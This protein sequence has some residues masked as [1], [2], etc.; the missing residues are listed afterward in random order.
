M[1]SVDVLQDIGNKNPDISSFFFHRFPTQRLLQQAFN[2]WTSTEE[3]LFD[4]ALEMKK[5]YQL[6]FWDGIMLGQFNTPHYSPK[7][8]KAALHHNTITEYIQVPKEYVAIRCMDML[9]IYPRI[10]VCSRICMKDKNVLHIPVIDFHI[11]V[12]NQN[13]LIAI[14]CCLALGFQQGYLLNSG[15]SYHFIG[16]QL[17]TWE[18]LSRILF[19][20]LMFSPIIDKAWI[21]HQLLEKSCSLRISKKHDVYPTVVEQL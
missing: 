10:A 9:Q 13:A 3:Q 21:S 20:A 6:L 14:D 15:E 4:F 19:R 17:M 7:G 1:T 18:E 8:L 5:N 16:T 2:E 12:S 11:P